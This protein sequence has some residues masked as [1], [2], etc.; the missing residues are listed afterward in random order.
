MENQVN[1]FDNFNGR[2]DLVWDK[3][4]ESYSCIVELEEGDHYGQLTLSDSV[5]PHPVDK[6]SLPGI[7]GAVEPQ[8]IILRII[9]RN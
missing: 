1:Y 9:P 5:N 8:V 3:R 6:F 2:C 4:E 7:S